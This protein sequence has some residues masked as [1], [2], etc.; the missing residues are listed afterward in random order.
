MVHTRAISFR[1]L[2]EIEPTEHPLPLEQQDGITM[3]RVRQ[4]AEAMYHHNA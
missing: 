3:D 1:P 4:I 2:I